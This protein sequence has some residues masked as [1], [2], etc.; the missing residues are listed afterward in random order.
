MNITDFLPPELVIPRLHASTKPAVI[1]ELAARV[2]EAYPQVEL[3]PLVRL[4]LEREQLGSTALGEGV[5]VPHAKIESIGRL[6]ACF[7]RSRKGIDFGAS[8]GQRSFFFFLLLAPAASTGEHLKALARISRLFRNESLRTRLV[9]AET[10]EEIR[11]VIAEEDD[12]S[13]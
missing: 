9:E 8:D 6:V 13:H 4:L 7:G 12:A 11:A 10:A 3:D 1:R 2:A 5:A